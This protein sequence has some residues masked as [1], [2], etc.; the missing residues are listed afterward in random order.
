MHRTPDQIQREGL[1]A[2][3]EKLGRAGM[4][5]FLQQFEH[6]A[7]DYPLQRREWLDK[8]SLDEIKKLSSKRKRRRRLG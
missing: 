1:A 8:T 6:G 5:R 3:R 4:V 7:G 2:L